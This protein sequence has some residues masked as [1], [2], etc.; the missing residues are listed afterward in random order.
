VLRPRSAG[1]GSIQVY[2]MYCI[3]HWAVPAYDQWHL[4]HGEFAVQK[5]LKMPKRSATPA[6]ARKATTPAPVLPM[7]PDTEEEH[8]T[9]D[10]WVAL[11]KAALDQVDDRKKA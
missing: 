4:R 8:A 9:L 3:E 2:G 11:G 6:D 10:K 7:L 1:L 5:I